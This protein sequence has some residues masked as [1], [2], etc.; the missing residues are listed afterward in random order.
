MI[1]SDAPDGAR[2]FF[3]ITAAACRLTHRQASGS[4]CDEGV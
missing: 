1:R 4:M 3:G 2:S